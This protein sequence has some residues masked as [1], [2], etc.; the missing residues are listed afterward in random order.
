MAYGP[1]GLNRMKFLTLNVFFV[2][3]TADGHQDMCEIPYRGFFAQESLG[4][5]F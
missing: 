4:S 1:M 2:V 3:T 5:L